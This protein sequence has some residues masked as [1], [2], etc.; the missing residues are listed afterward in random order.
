[1]D[2]SHTE[3]HIL[4]FRLLTGI[5]ALLMLL[6]VVTVG[7][8]YVD[9]GLG[10]VMAALIVATIKAGL[11]IAYFMHARYASTTIK[12][13]LFAAFVLLAIAIGFTF[14]DVAYR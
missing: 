12:A 7:V 14:F 10:H 2:H 8:A 9:T 5:W 4:S 13:M 11:V 1:M 6:T 3:Q